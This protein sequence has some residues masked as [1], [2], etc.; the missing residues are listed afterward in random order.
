MAAMTTKQRTAIAVATAVVMLLVGAL[1]WFRS[2]PA[3]DAVKT[4]TNVAVS[5]A[6]VGGVT[7]FVVWLL[8]RYAYEWKTA[9][10]ETNTA[11][12]TVAEH[13]Q[14]DFLEPVT[15]RDPKLSTDPFGEARGIYRGV[16]VRLSVDSYD[17]D[18]LYTALLL[19]HVKL[20]KEQM[21]SLKR[22]ADS[23]WCDDAGVTLFLN[24]RT[25]HNS[26]WG[27][28]RLPE[29]DTVRI[30]AALDHACDLVGQAE[31]KARQDS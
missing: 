6:A 27:L 15:C 20:D 26:A 21:S 8:R 7:L 12:R 5:L 31:P 17:S 4:V 9:Q 13:L 23:A 24:R 3:E 29:V 28:G 10:A 19:E 2:S 16:R 22:F 14:F 30:I 18:S 11:L 1:F 25:S